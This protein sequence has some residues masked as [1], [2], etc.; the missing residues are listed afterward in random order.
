MLKCKRERISRRSRL[1]SQLGN[2]TLISTSF[3]FFKGA[4]GRVSSNRLS[5]FR[6]SACWVKTGALEAGGNWRPEERK[7]TVSA[8]LSPSARALCSPL[9]EATRQHLPERALGGFRRPT[10]TPRSPA[11]N[12]VRGTLPRGCRVACKRWKMTNILSAQRIFQDQRDKGKLS[13]NKVTSLNADSNYNFPPYR[14]RSACHT[15]KESKKNPAQFW[16]TL[17]GTSSHSVWQW[18]PSQGLSLGAS[19]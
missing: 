9:H 13:K 11:G 7:Q 1:P 5:S 12:P 2:S 16:P 6:P 18:Q 4:W 10:L 19:P 8:A 3:P 17:E 15:G 14:S